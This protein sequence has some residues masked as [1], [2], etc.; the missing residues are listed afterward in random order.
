[1]KDLTVELKVGIFA[2]IVIMVLT[3]MTFKIG[4]LPLIW[5]KGYRLYVVLDDTNGLDE[6]SR[7]KIAGVEAG[8]VDRIDLLDGR[9]KITIV[10]NPDVKVYENAVISLRMSGL[11]GDRHLALTTGS[12]DHPLLRNGDNILNIRPATDIDMLA[13]KLTA[14]ASNIGELTNNINSIFGENER[15][16]IKEAIQ[17]LSVVTGTLKEIAETNKVPLNNIIARLEK[18]T[19]VLDE[20]GPGV[21]EDISELT[22]TINEKAPALIDDL[23]I[24]AKELKEIM[25]ENRDAF[26]DSMV[27]IRNISASAGVIAKRLERGEGTL[28]KLLQ[29][30]E[31]YDSLNKVTTEAGKSMEV[32]GNLRTYMDFHAEYNTKDEESKGY[33]ELTLQPRDDKYYILGVTTDPMG[34]VETIDR[35]TN[36]VLVREEIVE[37]EVEFT[38]QYARRFDNIALRVGLMENTFGAGADYFFNSDAG[39][40]KFDIWDMNGDEARAS[41]AHARLGVDYRVFKFLFVSGGV[42]NILNSRRRGLYFGGGLKF[43]DMDLKYLLGS[44]PGVSLN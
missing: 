38:I 21:M 11:L 36:G 17:N 31:L 15:S 39:R 24:A 16:A 8:M 26:R 13:S 23:T 3:Y 29:E 35:T 34:S 1:M 43:E 5:E 2:I 40:V 4:S 22:S 10:M 18:F 32:I 6:K 44:M 41:E 42:D 37:S 33:F 19:E 27:N 20:K 28:G 14:A 7:I 12:S 30:D 9:A 25:L